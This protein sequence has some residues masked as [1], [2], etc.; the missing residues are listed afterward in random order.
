MSHEYVTVRLM[1]YFILAGLLSIS[2]FSVTS[3]FAAEG[4][5]PCDGPDCGSCELVTLAS[6]VLTFFIEVTVSIGI[7][8]F[9][10]GG[11]TMVMSAGDTGKV[12][13]GKEMMSN[14]VIGLVIV[15]SA[16]LLM[17]TALKMVVG[18]G[19]QAYGVWKKISCTTHTQPST[20]STVKSTTT[21]NYP[22][23][24][25]TGRYT[26]LLS[27]CA[28]D[29]T[30]CSANTL[31]SLGFTDAQANVMS[32]LAMTES[33]GDPSKR[34]PSPKST[35]CGTFQVLKSTW[36]STPRSTECTSFLT[37]TNATCNMQVAKKL[38][39]R[40]GY[41]SWTCP[42]CNAKAQACVNKYG[43]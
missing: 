8:M 18:E 27:T 15:L 33:S 24:Y 5:V 28:P 25:G 43:G 12:S 4:L 40:S 13:K 42:N 7:V 39:D 29:N 6:N 2:L 17:D 37:C 41:S 26:G 19:S 3:V 32:C 10:I 9:V 31:K 14:A 23:I 20:Y 16:W 22:P 1:R 38:F 21:P 35:A 36:E 34:N 30:A 11:L